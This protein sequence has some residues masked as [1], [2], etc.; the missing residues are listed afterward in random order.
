MSRVTALVL[1]VGAAAAVWIALPMMQPE[2]QQVWLNG[3]GRLAG[4][5]L[6]GRDVMG[7]LA[8]LAVWILALHFPDRP[9]PITFRHSAT[10]AA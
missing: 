7:I 6:H 1:A 4:M 10:A 5:T 9:R 3:A 2:L 8:G